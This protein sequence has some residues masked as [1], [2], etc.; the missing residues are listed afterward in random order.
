MLRTYCLAAITLVAAM[1]A[2]VGLTASEN[3]SGERTSLHYKLIDLGTF[4]GPTNWFCYVPPASPVNATCPVQNSSGTVV[5]GADSYL[6]NPHYANPNPFLW[7]QTGVGDPYTQHA[8]QWNGG[9][10]QDLGTLPGGHNSTAFGLSASGLTTGLSEDGSVDPLTGWPAVHAVLW[11]NN[12]NT[13]VDLGTLEGG[14]ES[15]GSD[16]NSQGQVVG[17]ALNT[18]PDH[19]F[20]FPTQTRAFS[21]KNGVMRTW[22]RLAPV[23]MPSPCS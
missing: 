8:F 18:I 11:K 10:L 4:G 13:V 21:W 20:Y 22:V 15:S 1:S 23:P 5:G 6:P 3:H 2:P 14:Y 17:F 7:P 9:A 19:V 16:V 12:G